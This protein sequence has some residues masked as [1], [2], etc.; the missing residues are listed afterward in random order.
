MKKLVPMLTVL[1]IAYAFVNAIMD[2]AI[3]GPV[4]AII[5]F[6][7]V[8]AC[9]WVAVVS[10]KDTVK[11]WLADRKA[12]KAAEKAEAEAAEAARVAQIVGAALA[13]HGIT[14]PAA[15]PAP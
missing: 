12:K 13:A 3:Y 4:G 14:A 2:F 9:L 7:I 6:F 15:P 8:I 1:I 11:G 5:S 10:S